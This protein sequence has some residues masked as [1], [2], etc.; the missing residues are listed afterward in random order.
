M[1]TEPTDHT[2]PEKSPAPS[3]DM[4][5]SKKTPM[6]PSQKQLPNSDDA[7]PYKAEI[8]NEEGDPVGKL[9]QL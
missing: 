4:T 5:P 8:E 2:I 6:S 3:G 9:P 1:V 7:N